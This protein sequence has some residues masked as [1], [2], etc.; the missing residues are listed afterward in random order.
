M[1]AA[2]PLLQDGNAGLVKL[3]VDAH[4]RRRIL[5][6]THT[7]MTLP[8]AGIAQQVALGGGAAEAELAVLR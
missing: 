8:L 6:L 1:C 7:Y 5:R 4:T 3:V 2:S